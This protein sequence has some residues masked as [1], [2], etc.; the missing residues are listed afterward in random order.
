MREREKGREGAEDWQGVNKPRFWVDCL[1]STRVTSHFVSPH[2]TPIHLYSIL[3]HQAPPPPRGRAH[4][5]T[6]E[7]RP[8]LFALFVG[9]E[10]RRQLSPSLLSFSS[11]DLPHPTSPPSSSPPS[12]DGPQVR[13]LRP[14]SL[15]LGL[16][17]PPPPAHRR[18]DV[19]ARGGRRL[20]Q[21]LQ[22]LERPHRQG[23]QG[24]R[25]GPRRPRAPG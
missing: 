16:A 5:L 22:R 1:H 21:G 10:L 20:R 6:R 9:L 12:H 25:R 13:H 14:L 4:L 7:R 15:T 8:S 19:R 17:R 24:R 3:L 11:L 2:S 23:G 18:A